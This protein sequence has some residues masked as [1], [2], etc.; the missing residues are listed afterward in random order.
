MKRIFCIILLLCLLAPC[1][2]ADSLDT[3]LDD[4]NLNVLA[5]T[6]ARELAASEF[7]A[8]TIKGN[9]YYMYNKDG[10]VILISKEGRSYSCQSADADTFLRCAV[11]IAL[12]NMEDQSSSLILSYMMFHF[13]TCTESE[14]ELAALGSHVFK[15]KYTGDAY[16]FTM[17][18]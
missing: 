1:A 4:Y 13:L 16:S 18:K 17:V 2:L 7:S 11:T 3:F 10:L 6:G 8:T 9:P 15:T 14:P 5:L 12:T